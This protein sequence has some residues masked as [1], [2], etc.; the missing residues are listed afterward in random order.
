LAN[1]KAHLLGN[2]KNVVFEDTN[3]GMFS[4]DGQDSEIRTKRE[5]VVKIKVDIRSKKP[6]EDKFMDSQMETGRSL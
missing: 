5:E 3:M 2:M 1:Y 6:Q 4:I